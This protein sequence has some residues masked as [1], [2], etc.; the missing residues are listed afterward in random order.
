MTIRYL[1][2][3]APILLG[4]CYGVAGHDEVDR[5]F[6]RSDSITMTAGDAKQVNAVTHTIHPWPRYVGDRRIAYDARRV[7]AAVT[8]YG[9][10]QQP[11]DQLPD[12]GDPTKLM[13]QRPPVTQN[14]NVTGL[15][16][17]A[18]AGVSVPVGGAAGR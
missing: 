17:G 13:G 8:R 7:G 6:Q 9:N 11:V 15:G 16:A 14:V 1:V 5:Y 10:Q 2:L 12:M 4:G 18:S 3:F